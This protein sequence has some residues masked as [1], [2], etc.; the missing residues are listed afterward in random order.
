MLAM[1]SSVPGLTCAGGQG[2]YQQFNW[3]ARVVGVKS[4]AKRN[5]HFSQLLLPLASHDT[6]RSKSYRIV[7]S[8]VQP[9][10]SGNKDYDDHDADDVKNVHSTLRLRHARLQDESTMLQ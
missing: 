1:A 3:R 10:E 7:C 5:R 6:I 2:Q 4:W 9:Q 8:N